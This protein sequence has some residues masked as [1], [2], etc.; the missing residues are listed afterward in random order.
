MYGVF[1]AYCLTAI[2]ENSTAS[3]I[4][5]IGSIRVFLLCFIGTPLGPFYDSS[6]CRPLLV[7]GTFLCTFG[8]FIPRD[9]RN[10]WQILLAQ[11]VATGS[12]MACLFLPELLS[13]PSILAP[14]KHSPRVLRLLGAV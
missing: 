7:A 13:F 6:F 5:W 9:W 2:A 8:M 12:G 14:G 3:A 11:D 10:Y 1:Q 4:S